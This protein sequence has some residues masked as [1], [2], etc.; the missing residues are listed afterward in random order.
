MAW[1]QPRQVD[2][3][4][5]IWGTIDVASSQA[6]GTTFTVTLPIRRSIVDTV[7]AD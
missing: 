4:N 5:V 7:T 3:L 6:H 1:S 2:L